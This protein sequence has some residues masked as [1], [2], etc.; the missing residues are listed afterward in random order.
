MPR[1]IRVVFKFAGSLVI[2]IH[3]DRFLSISVLV[4]RLILLEKLVRSDLLTFRESG[5][6]VNL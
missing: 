5:F 3:F 1:E 4:M 6:G 2:N